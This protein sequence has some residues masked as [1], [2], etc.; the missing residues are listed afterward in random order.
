MHS[1][2]KSAYVKLDTCILSLWVPVLY[3]CLAKRVILWYHLHNK[4]LFEPNSGQGKVGQGRARQGQFVLFFHR[5]TPASEAPRVSQ[6]TAL[7]IRQRQ[8]L[9]YSCIH[10]KVDLCHHDVRINRYR[11]VSRGDGPGSE[12]DP[13]LASRIR[14]RSIFPSC[15]FNRGTAS[16]LPPLNTPAYL[17]KA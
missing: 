15:W 5:S 17:H 8:Q 12:A 1:D 3:E 10:V 16:L 6:N 9:L 7:N 11:L 4:F 2:T 14:P 13:G